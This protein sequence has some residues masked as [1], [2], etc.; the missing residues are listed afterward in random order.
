[1]VKSS[2]PSLN[3]EMLTFR[4]IDS[5]RT[6]DREGHFREEAQSLLKSSCIIS[7]AK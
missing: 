2:K 1:M 7:S 4:K 3:P 5:Y 6:R